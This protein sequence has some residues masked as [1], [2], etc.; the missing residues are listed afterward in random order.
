[1]P[2]HTPVEAAR[3]RMGRVG[4][5]IAGRTP[6]PADAWRR[7][8]PRLER[9]GY[10][11]VWSNEGV[12]GKETFAQLGVLLAASDRLV[13]ASGIANMWA[14]H[15]AAMQAG[16]ATLADAYPGRF[17]LGVGASHPSRAG[18]S[19][20]GFRPVPAMRDYLDR[21][22]AS[23]EL[24]LPPAT[25]FPRVLAA[26]GPRML[27]LAAERADGAYPAL[28]PVE[29]TR[30]ARAALGPD[31]LLVV[32][33][34][35]MLDPDR[36]RARQAVP[37]GTSLRPGSPYRANLQRLGYTDAQLDDPSDE[38]VDAISAAGDERLIADRVGAHLDAGADHVV[39]MPLAADLPAIADQLERLAP[40][41]LG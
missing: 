15:P 41:L 31:R 5:G 20:A 16:A 36:G 24:T 10:G 12:G 32:G 4:A 2:G 1:M 34:G 23:S 37:V 17:V 22:D 8:L 25:P 30:L 11:S 7:E 6:P 38:L 18:E 26:L 35:T 3:R 13:V 29:H 40:A 19:G 27:A 9:L 14:R 28:T 21:M 39:V 33:L